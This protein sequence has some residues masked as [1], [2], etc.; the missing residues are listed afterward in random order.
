MGTFIC[1]HSLPIYSHFV[2]RIFIK[3]LIIIYMFT[4]IHRPYMSDTLG[5]YISLVNNSIDLIVSY[6]LT[7]FNYLHREID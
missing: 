5:P 4:N 3:T 7:L 2:Y 1:S 6:C